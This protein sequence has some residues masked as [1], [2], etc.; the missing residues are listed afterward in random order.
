MMKFR[1]SFASVAG[2]ITETLS[3][4]SRMI[5]VLVFLSLLAV[6]PF[7]HAH[8]IPNFRQVNDVIYRGG[9]PSA[10]DLQELKVMGV[11]TILNLENDRKPVAAEKNVAENLKFKF[12]SVPTASFFKP[13]DQDVDHV[14]AV[15]ADPA[16]YPVFIHCTHGEDR[17]GLMMGLYRVEKEGWRADK[18]YAEMLDLGF[19]KAL[20]ALDDYFEDR[21]GLGGN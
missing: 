6:A 5:K 15:L 19:H 4:G 10:Q 11:K 2:K 16:N 18:A 9:R 14:L 13:K 8:Q 12:I 20:F 21:S 1:T 17:T 3:E 7:S